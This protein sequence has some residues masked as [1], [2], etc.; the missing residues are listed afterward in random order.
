VAYSI[1][2]RHKGV[3]ITNNKTSNMIILINTLIAIAGFFLGHK[4]QT[5]LAYARVKN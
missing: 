3:T 4:I 2:E 1:S 5:D